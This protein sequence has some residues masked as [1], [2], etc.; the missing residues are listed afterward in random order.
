ML[1]ANIIRVNLSPLPNQIDNFILLA[2]LNDR[3]ISTQSK[4]N[5]NNQKYNNWNFQVIELHTT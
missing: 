5:F 2:Y 1:S 4:L 3:Y